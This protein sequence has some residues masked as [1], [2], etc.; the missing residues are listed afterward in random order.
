MA[1]L[2]GLVLLAAVLLVRRWKPAWSHSVIPRGATP[3]LALVGFL[4]AALA[5]FGVGVDRVIVNSGHGAGMWFADGAVSLIAAG[6]CL[7]VLLWSLLDGRTRSPLS[8]A[9]V[10]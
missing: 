10:R 7:T 8:G 3:A 2:L 9:A 6:G 5:L 4:P 1:G